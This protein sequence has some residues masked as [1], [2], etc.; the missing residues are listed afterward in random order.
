M[1][2]DHKIK[3]F[4]A[5]NRF[6]DLRIE[7]IKEAML[8]ANDAGND[9]TKSSAGDKHET[10]R[11]MAQLEQE[12]QS[13]QLTSALELKELLSRL[14]LN[15]QHTTITTGSLIKTNQGAFFISIGA[16]KIKLGDFQCMTISPNSPL[17]KV[18]AGKQKDASVVFN[19]ITYLIEDVI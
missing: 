1:M 15:I 16:G 12:K 7:T 3:L 9:E 19:G 2:S 5:L 6:V 8:A 18:F 11:A 13:I 14:N 10:G 4:E 17:A